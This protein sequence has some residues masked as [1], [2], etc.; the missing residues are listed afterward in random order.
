MASGTASSFA[1]GFHRCAVPQSCVDG[2]IAPT[3]LLP[4]IHPAHILV[5]PQQDP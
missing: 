2:T 1:D 5:S 4:G 3:P